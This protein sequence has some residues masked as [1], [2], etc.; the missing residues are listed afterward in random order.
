[1]QLHNT[2]WQVQMSALSSIS[3]E[4]EERGGIA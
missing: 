2:L 4:R 1:M 3:H